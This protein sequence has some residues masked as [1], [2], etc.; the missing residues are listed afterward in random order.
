MYRL[1]SIAIYTNAEEDAEHAPS[2]LEKNGSLDEAIVPHTEYGVQENVLRTK[3]RR[4]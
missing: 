3:S 4:V 2:R 1:F